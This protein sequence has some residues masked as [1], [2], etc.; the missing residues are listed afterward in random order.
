MYTDLMGAARENPA[1]QESCPR[2]GFRDPPQRDGIASFLLNGHFFSMNGMSSNGSLDLTGVHAGFS[3]DEG[4]IRLFHIA[5]FELVHEMTMGFI[6]L[7][8]NE[9]TARVLVQPMYDPRTL[10]ASNATQVFAAMM[11]KPMYKRRILMARSGVHHK[12]GR[13][14]DDNEMFI[15][16]ED[17][18][19]HLPGH[20]L[21]RFRGRKTDCD[22]VAC[23]YGVAG[24][25]TGSSVD[26][27][28]SLA[29]QSLQHGS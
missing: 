17:F 21:G 26:E 6:G 22:I 23:L 1:L 15:L 18:Q 5:G 11:K 20:E 24:K 9:A 13:F 27:N 29:N 14:V 7:G 16:Q 4:E 12:S 25:Q 10:D 2:Q 19:M 8:N 3:P 28:M